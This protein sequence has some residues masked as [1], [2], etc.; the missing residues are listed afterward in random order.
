MRKPTKA[1]P[2]SRKMRRLSTAMLREMRH[3]IMAARM[4]RM[5]TRQAPRGVPAAHQGAVVLDGFDGVTG[6]GGLETAAPAEQRAQG[7]AICADDQ[8]QEAL[9]RLITSCQCRSRLAR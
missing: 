3:R 8:D 5:A 4:E 1:R 7:I 9:H 6:T 2:A